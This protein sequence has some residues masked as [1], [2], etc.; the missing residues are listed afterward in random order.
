MKYIG[1]ILLV[2]LSFSCK[3]KKVEDT[4]K[5]EKPTIT[6]VN[7]SIPVTTETLCGSSFNNVLK[8]PVGDTLKFTFLFKAANPLSQYK[9]D[10]HANFDCHDHGK[11]AEWTV[12]KMGDLTGSE[13]TIT[14]QFAIPVNVAEGN[15]HF[16]IRLLDIYGYEAE[17]KEFNVIIYNPIDTENPEVTINSPANLSTLVKG[18]QVSFQGLIT[19]NYSLEGGKFQFMFTDSQNTLYNLNEEFYPTGTNTSYSINF[20]YTIGSFIPTGQG[21]FTIKAFDS[22]NNFSTKIVNVTITE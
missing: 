5:S 8:I 1:I 2:F 6:I 22:V 20:N 16:M 13:Q 12:I 15:Y 18:S 17:T 21:Y 10:A 11:S 4:P 7:Q 3:K 19:D 9:I 14:E